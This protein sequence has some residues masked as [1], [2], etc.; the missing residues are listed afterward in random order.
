M[1]AANKKI[2]LRKNIQNKIYIKSLGTSDKILA[3]KERM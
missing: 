1:S 3:D 2:H